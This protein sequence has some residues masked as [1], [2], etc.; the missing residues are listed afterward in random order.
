MYLTTERKNLISIARRRI[1]YLRSCSARSC[2]NNNHRLKIGRIFSAPN[3]MCTFLSLFNYSI[4][5]E[6]Q[7][8]F[9]RRHKMAYDGYTVT[10]V[11]QEIHMVFR[12]SW[13]QYTHV[14]NS[15][16][17]D[18]AMTRLFFHFHVVVFFQK[19]TT[20]CTATSLN[21]ETRVFSSQ[22]PF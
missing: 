7:V 18:W 17:T 9:A 16:S 10:R 21:A 1:Y 15:V 2:Y 11:S 6:T 5:L 12:E 4:F 22:D 14:N 8:W 13:N 20:D 19:T 3:K